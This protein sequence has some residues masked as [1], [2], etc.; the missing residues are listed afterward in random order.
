MFFGVFFG[1]FAG[2]QRMVLAILT[3]RLLM[4]RK[5][6]NQTNKQ[7]VI[8]IFRAIT[9]INVLVGAVGIKLVDNSLKLYFLP[10][11]VVWLV[12]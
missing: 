12:N 7:T 10:Y 8:G 9:E 4:E 1:V 2:G 5:E 6:S 11:I 3:E